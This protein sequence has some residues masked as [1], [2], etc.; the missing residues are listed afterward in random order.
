MPALR[1]YL[2]EGGRE[3]ERQTDS[4]REIGLV[5]FEDSQKGHTINCHIDVMYSKIQIS[6]MIP[7]LRLC[8]V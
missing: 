4:A 7:A 8:G 2:G 5:T 3:R 6:A 1:L